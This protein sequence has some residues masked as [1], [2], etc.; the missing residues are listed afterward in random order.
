MQAMNDLSAYGR[1]QLVIINSAIF[2][3]FAFSFYRPQSSRDWRTFGAFSAF[4][5]ALFTE[6]YGFPLTVYLISGWLGSR[7][8]EI[9]WFSHNSGHLLQTVLGWQGD[10][11]FAPFH[12]I[13]DIFIWGGLILLGAS[14]RV[15]FKAQCYN[16]LATTG[17]YARIRHPQYAAFILIM[18]G[19]LIQW[20]TLP[21][22]IMFPVLVFVYVRLA[23]R[24]ENDSQKAFGE[25]YTRYAGQTPRFIPRFFHLNVK[26]IGNGG[27]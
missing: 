1:W 17:P 4:L 15:L 11:H 25:L 3:F 6:M 22:L 12:L 2:L 5:I 8:P 13:S 27:L 19:F 20:P 18:M 14:W 21:T 7:Y 23:L 10:P 24:E 26:P 16:Q 9:D